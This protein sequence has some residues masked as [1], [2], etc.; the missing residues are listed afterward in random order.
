M[1]DLELV[2]RGRTLE[3]EFSDDFHQ[4]AIDGAQTVLAQ[5]AV[6]HQGDA[7]VDGGH[8]S[9]DCTERFFPA[10]CI[11]CGMVVA[12]VLGDCVTAHAQ[13]DGGRQSAGVVTILLDWLCDLRLDVLSAGRL[14]V[15]LCAAIRQGARQAGNTDHDAD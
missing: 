12:G 7:A 14:R 11:E 3:E 8:R 1:A 13:L 10:A 4:P 2:Q 15:C 9:R 5:A 6:F